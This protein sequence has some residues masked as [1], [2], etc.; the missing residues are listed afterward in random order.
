VQIGIVADTHDHLPMI[1]LA[2]EAFQREGVE[3][4]L[5]AGDFVAPF[6]V[7]ELLRF[8]GKVYAVFGN[9]DGEKKG[10]RAAGLDVQKPPRRLE[11]GGRVIILAHASEQVERKPGLPAGSSPH[12]GGADVIIT[13]HTHKPS[14]KGT[15]P[16][17][18]NPGEC[19]GWLTGRS[20]VA[21]LDTGS[22]KA[23]L[24]EIG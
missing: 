22:L 5:H 1:R 20:T 8:R 3:V 17:F 6:A 14:I 16:V 9:N 12:K 7:K 18:I 4:L 15:S 23:R 10:I 13:G 19:G 24:V 11:L 21:I 2:L